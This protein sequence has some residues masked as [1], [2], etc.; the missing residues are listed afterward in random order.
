MMVKIYIFSVTTIDQTTHFIML[1][2]CSVSKL[3]SG[4]YLVEYFEVG[5]YYDY[6]YYALETKTFDLLQAWWL[7]R[8][9]IQLK[10]DEMCPVI[11]FDGF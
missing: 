8:E 2:F 4:R 10:L 11:T 6:Y 5:Y 3:F 1:A 9:T 7:Q